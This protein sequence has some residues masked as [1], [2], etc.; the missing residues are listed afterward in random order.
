MLNSPSAETGSPAELKRD[1]S[2]QPCLAESGD[3]H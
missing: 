2:F 1:N 3:E